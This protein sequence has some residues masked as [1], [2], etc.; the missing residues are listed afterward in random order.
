MKFGCECEDI[1]GDPCDS[2]LAPHGDN[3]IRYVRPSMRQNAIAAGYN[4]AT[5]PGC[6]FARVCDRCLRFIEENFNPWILPDDGENRCLSCGE[7]I[8]P[9][10]YCEDC[11]KEVDS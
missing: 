2:K 8:C 9:S 1:F 7:I 10:G 3:V 11:Q 4:D 6:D 5:W